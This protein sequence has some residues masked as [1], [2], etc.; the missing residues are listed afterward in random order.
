MEDA[1]RIKE[2][3]DCRDWVAA[4]L[5]EPEYKNGDHWK[6]TCPF[7]GDTDPSLAVYQNGFYCFG[8]DAKG[9]V[10]DW[11]MEFQNLDFKAATQVIESGILTSGSYRAQA[12]VHQRIAK[13]KKQRIRVLAAEVKW[14]E[15]YAD[16]LLK[17]A[18]ALEYLEQ[19]GVD[20]TMAE[21]FGL[22]Y[23]ESPW[24]PAISIPWKVGGELRGIQYRMIHGDGHMRYRWE[25]R[26]ESNP[27]IFNA[28]TIHSGSKP[29]WITEGALKSVIL[30]KHGLDSCAIINKQGWKAGW[31]P[32]FH[33]RQ[34]YVALDPDARDEAQKIASDIGSNAKVVQLPRKPDDLLVEDGWKV[35]NLLAWARSGRVAE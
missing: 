35:E 30:V 5:G 25:N 23:R 6:W 22:G 20:Y 27:T 13:A 26:M 33:Q 16:A 7:H 29:L 14:H 8:C 10:I 15:E 17:H 21:H 12:Q 2:A 32:H 34:V 9:D 19:R 31:A 28:D 4:T 1:A 11:V 24:G 3:V 18:E